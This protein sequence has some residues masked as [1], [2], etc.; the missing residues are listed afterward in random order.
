MTNI[1][2]TQIGS[3]P[4]ELPLN[5]DETL[6]EIHQI[7]CSAR[8]AHTSQS[9]IMQMSPINMIP[10]QIATNTN[11]VHG[12]YRRHRR[13]RRRH[14]HRRRTERN[15][16]RVHEHRAQQEES[17][18]R[19]ERHRL[20]RYQNVLERPEQQEQA[21]SNQNRTL[22]QHSPTTEYYLYYSSEDDQNNFL[23]TYDWETLSIQR[24]HNRTN[25]TELAGFE[26]LKQLLFPED[27]REQSERILP[28][29]VI[30]AEVERELER[31]SNQEQHGL[32]D[33]ETIQNH[34]EMQRNAGYTEQLQQ[35]NTVEHDDYQRHLSLQERPRWE[36]QGQHDLLSISTAPSS[37][38][39]FCELVYEPRELEE[40]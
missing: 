25:I 40:P 35:I 23:E 27:N 33:F 8:I 1:N 18:E 3:I 30:D 2:C 10:N 28:M 39:I 20:E 26:R 6:T 37:D 32:T 29:E 7:V 15:I 17:E 16:H 11:S 19:A 4:S 22:N 24:S 13:R 36:Q 34:S 31:I 38:W 21:F 12:S 5:S 14:H 9:S